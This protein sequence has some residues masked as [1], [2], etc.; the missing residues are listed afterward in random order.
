MAREKGEEGNATEILFELGS[1]W[2]NPPPGSFYPRIP[3]DESSRF[4]PF[5][6]QRFCAL[7]AACQSTVSGQ[8]PGPPDGRSGILITVAFILISLTNILIE[9]FQEFFQQVC[10]FHY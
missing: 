1:N 8:N 6:L 10:S 9:Y 2:I 3:R 5:L 4:F 7:A